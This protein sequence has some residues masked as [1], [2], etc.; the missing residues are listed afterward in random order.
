MSQNVPAHDRAFPALH[1][2]H[3][4]LFCMMVS[5]VLMQ[6]PVLGGAMFLSGQVADLSF[7][8]LPSE[9]SKH[10]SR[11]ARA[12]MIVLSVLCSVLTLGLLLIYPRK[13]GLQKMWLLFA[14]ALLTT[15]RS[16]VCRKIMVHHI[17]SGRT[18]L[19]T[20]LLLGEATLFF[21]IICIPVLFFSL[22]TEDAW[23][24]WGSFAITSILE[25]VLLAKTKDDPSFAAD[26]DTDVLPDEH[27]LSSI[28]AYRVF[29]R[30]LALTMAALQVT[31][32]MIYTFVGTTMSDL[33]AGMAVAFV[34]TVA[35]GA[36]TG[37]I[38]RRSP[39]RDP[40]NMLL[41][42]LFLWMASLLAF[43]LRHHSVPLA[44]LALAT[45]SAGTATAITAFAQLDSSMREVI[46]FATGAPPDKRL[47][48]ALSIFLRYTE[49]AG[50]MVALL[51]L[52][53]AAFL[54]STPGV[55]RNSIPF[56]PV[57]LLP[58]L[59]LVA[60]A[61]L[62]ALRFP[63]R[64]EH[65]QKLH[66]FLALQ[67]KGET[68][69][70]L[71]KQLEDV[72]IKVSKRHYGVRVL[73]FVTRLFVRS[74]VYGTEN[75]PIHE[76]ASIVFICNHGE[77]YGPIVASVYIPF[78]VRPWVMSEMVNAEE[79][80]DYIYEGTF[81]R[82]K[83]LPKRL[84]YPL[85]RMVTPII[86]RSMEGVGSIP[87]YRNKPRELIRTFRTTVDMMEAGDHILIFPENPFD[88][89]HYTGSYLREGV[90]EFF[91]GFTMVAPLYYK[92][93]GKR[94]VF[95]PMYADKKRQTLTFG[96]PVV[97]DPDNEPN[98]EKERLCQTLRGEMLRMAGMEQER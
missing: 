64:K 97:Y 56:Q 54:S 29:R 92:R 25:A 78:P 50:Q 10:L 15:L 62:F 11:T 27:A 6:Q 89:R 85:A 34:C 49:L 82:Q 53:L 22:S 39:E 41:C 61:V 84:R 37:R 51:G 75:V 17:K 86:S 2:L 33:F 59:L 21:I 20:R 5:T 44:Y 79:T 45:C 46:F 9:R 36:V 72:I 91:T 66:A 31:V 43:L 60:A 83:W 40:S 52:S 88:E 32:I 87:V 19:R 55:F 3:N 42:G 93:T 95:V 81:K 76:D 30:V 18:L 35:V 96:P 48:A 47:D 58:A 74:H 94:C 28:N 8:F 65:L 69:R 13:V 57:L 1:T 77:I 38:A 16:L 7:R 67:T 90:G 12:A 71:Q 14:L 4:Y 98:A 63:L 80:T 70:P 73:K 26:V 23:Y 24:L 68:N